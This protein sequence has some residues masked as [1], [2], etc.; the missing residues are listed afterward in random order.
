MLHTCPTIAILVLL[1][2]GCSMEPGP[3]PDNVAD[4]VRTAVT[5]LTTAMNAHDADAVM[6]FYSDD[7]D[8]VYLGC[9]GFILG[10]PNFKQ[11]V[12]GYY[13]ARVDVVFQ[14]DV[15]SVRVLGS[16][17]AV[18]S[19]RGASTESP[20]LFTTQTWV[21]SQEGWKVAGVHESWPGCPEP[22]DPHPF[23]APSDSSELILP[24]SP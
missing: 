21:R 7:P 19:L 5:A 3:D 1:L 2:A 20:A 24:G 8:F 18:V 15:V 23:T 22:Q 16:D 6:A 14:Q 12:S 9:T 11:I 17:A 4:D 13:S 10:G